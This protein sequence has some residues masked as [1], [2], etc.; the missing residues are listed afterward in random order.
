[1]DDYS[2]DKV[3][4]LYAENGKATC[5]VCKNIIID[6]IETNCGHT[7][8]TTCVFNSIAF[9]PKSPLECPVCNLAI[10][11]IMQ[12]SACSD[13]RI[14]RYNNQLEKNYRHNVTCII[15]FITLLVLA[16]IAAGVML[17][18]RYHS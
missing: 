11:Q 12:N 10:I 16:C 6:G 3:V 4:F 18:I 5:P 8:C 15:V 2:N 14:K 13:D 1:M 9:I 17:Y 7:F